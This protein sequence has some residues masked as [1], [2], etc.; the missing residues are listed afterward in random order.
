V[1]ARPRHN[2]CRAGH[3]MRYEAI[4]SKERKQYERKH[5]S[6]SFKTLFFVGYIELRSELLT[7]L[8]KVPLA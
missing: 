5:T 1:T 7:P 8:Q 4:W 3:S 2:K 6:G